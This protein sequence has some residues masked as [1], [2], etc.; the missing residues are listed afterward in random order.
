MVTKKL[1]ILYNWKKNQFFSMQ[2]WKLFWLIKA[3]L[4]FSNFLSDKLSCLTLIVCAL[5]SP[6]VIH[7]CIDSSYINNMD[8]FANIMILTLVKWTSC[9]K[10]QGKRMS[11][12]YLGGLLKMGGGATKNIEG[13]EGCTSS[14]GNKMCDI[15]EGGS[16]KIYRLP[17]GW[18]R[19]KFIEWFRPI[20]PPIYSSLSVGYSIDFRDVRKKHLR[21]MTEEYDAGVFKI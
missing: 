3:I 6:S 5:N 14:G 15:L 1:K 19:W 4:V 11:I 8:I 2:L 20:P 9:K 21:N 7:T 18:G 12:Y 10:V 16:I 17:Q 13:V